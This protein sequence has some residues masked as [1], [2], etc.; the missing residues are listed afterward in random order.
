MYEL[1][2]WSPDLKTKLILK[3]WLF[4]AV[5]LTKNA[6]TD[7]Y[8]YSGYNIGFDLQSAFSLPD[9]GI[10]KYVIIFGANMS[11]SVF[12]DNKYLISS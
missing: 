8:K 7:K 10:W 2:R 3:D 9:S 11:S 1:D 5:K 12:L 4:A 6:D